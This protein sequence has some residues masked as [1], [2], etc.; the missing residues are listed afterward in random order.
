MNSSTS[1]I[2]DK[3]AALERMAFDQQLFGEMIGLLRDDGPRRMCDLRAALDAGDMSR[4][5]HAAHS[6]KGL[7]ANFNAART[8][9]AAAEVEQLAKRGEAPQRLAAA[10]PQLAEALDELLMELASH[11]PLATS[12]EPRPSRRTAVARS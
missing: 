5:H 7:A 12:V 3:H 8:V 10:V 11:V 6:L 9:Q 2:F 1:P 4:V